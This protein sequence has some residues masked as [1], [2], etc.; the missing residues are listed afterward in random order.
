VL[1]VTSFWDIQE[2]M[3]KRVRSRFSQ[4]K[5]MVPGLDPHSV[6][7]DTWGLL[8]CNSS[9]SGSGGRGDRGRCLPCCMHWGAS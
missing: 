1:G 3:E 8:T 5:L 4:A 6:R 9:S 2:A 7:G